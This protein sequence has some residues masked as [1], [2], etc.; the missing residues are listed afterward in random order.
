[1]RWSDGRVQF[2]S[3]YASYPIPRKH[4]PG[5]IF[6]Y[7]KRK[8]THLRHSWFIASL[9]SVLGTCEATSKR[10]VGS[11]ISRLQHVAVIEAQSMR[12]VAAGCTPGLPTAG[13]HHS[14][15]VCPDPWLYIEAY[16]K[17]VDRSGEHSCDPRQFLLQTSGCLMCSVYHI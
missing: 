7:F 10:G 3:A 14:L 5:L 9:M 11:T 2:A 6:P 8:D 17:Q 12:A 4:P 16:A 15:T 1:M 13:L